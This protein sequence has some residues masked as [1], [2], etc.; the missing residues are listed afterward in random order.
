MYIS[1]IK[2]SFFVDVQCHRKKIGTEPGQPEEQIHVAKN[3]K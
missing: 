2:Q 1:S 3:S